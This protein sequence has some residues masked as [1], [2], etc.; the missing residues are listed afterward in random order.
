L[1]GEEIGKKH[2]NDPAS[3]GGMSEPGE[4]APD[5]VSATDFQSVDEAV[6]FESYPAVPESVAKARR[7]IRRF[8]ARVGA[9]PGI[10]DDIQLAVSEAASNV[11]LHAYAQADATGEVRVDASV[12]AGE[13]LVSVADTGGGLRARSDSPG[14][15]LGLAIIGQLATKVEMLRG[16]NGGLRVCMHFPVTAPG[17]GG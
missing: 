14:L 13:L 10:L 16:D 9:A 12:E 3:G 15:G 5:D 11:V 4:H 1:A 8:A 7:S 6:F 17:G 2:G